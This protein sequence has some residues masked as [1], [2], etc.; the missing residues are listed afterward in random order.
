MFDIHFHVTAADTVSGCSRMEFCKMNAEYSL[1]F[2]AFPE[3]RVSS[4]A[5]RDG[6][7]FHIPAP[8]YTESPVF[9][10]LL[11]SKF[12]LSVRGA[13]G[14]GD[15]FRC[16]IPAASFPCRETVQ[17]CRRDPGVFVRVPARREAV[18]GGVSRSRSACIQFQKFNL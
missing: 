7:V 2:V 15:G 3:F 9:L 18:R 11:F 16:C 4:S 6:N 12:S 1:L 14:L 13:A 8:E 10:R 5:A 17:A